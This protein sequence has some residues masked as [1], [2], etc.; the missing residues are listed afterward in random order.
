MQQ[1]DTARTNGGDAIERLHWAIAVQLSDK[2]GAGTWDAEKMRAAVQ[3]LRD[4]GVT[5]EA[6]PGSPLQELLEALDPEDSAAADLA[7]IRRQASGRT[8]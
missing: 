3:F 7:R 8:S 1:A 6:Q 5:S 2:I 4:N